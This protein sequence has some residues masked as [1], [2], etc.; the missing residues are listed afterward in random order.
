MANGKIID[1]ENPFFSVTV[2]LRYEKNLQA[3]LDYTFLNWGAV[4]MID[5]HLQVMKE[6]DKFAFGLCF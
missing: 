4:T 1:K 5:F 3:T 2:S 6:I